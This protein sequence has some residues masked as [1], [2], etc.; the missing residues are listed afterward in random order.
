M[1]PFSS[2]F[3]SRK[4]LLLIL[5][6]FIALALYFLSRYAPVAWLE[7]TKFVIL[8]MQPVFIA[9]IASIAWEDAAAKRA[10]TFRFYG[11]NE[12]EETD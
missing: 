10:G 7:D 9:V 2:L 1:N 3:H 6:T 8:V 4:F 11:T 5:D 12:V